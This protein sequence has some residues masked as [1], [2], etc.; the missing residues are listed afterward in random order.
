MGKWKG[1]PVFLFSFPSPSLMALFCYFLLYPN[2]VPRAFPL[3]NGWAHFLREKPW[4]RGWLYPSDL[5]HSQI[6]RL[7]SPIITL[8]PCETYLDLNET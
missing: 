4:G 7:G 2:L 1:P 3:K 6:S 8:Q 5:R